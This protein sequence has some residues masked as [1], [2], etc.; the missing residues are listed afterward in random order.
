MEGSPLIEYKK[1]LRKR[2]KEATVNT[3]IRILNRFFKKYKNLKTQKD[4][5]N[6]IEDHIS[7]LKNDNTYNT[8][9]TAI[10]NYFDY[11]GWFNVSLPKRRHKPDSKKLPKDIISNNDLK[12]FFNAFDDTKDA[13]LKLKLICCIVLNTGL[14]SSVVTKLK[15]DDPIILKLNKSNEMIKQLYHEYL[16]R[17]PIL[18][19]QRS[20]FLFPNRNRY[21]KEYS[22]NPNSVYYLIKIFCEKHFSG[23]FEIKYQDL[24]N[25]YFANKKETDR[26]L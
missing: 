4:Y 24:Q 7:S 19:K 10:Q 26:D 25:Y 2:Y 9:I 18:D 13:E 12:R 15:V 22:M 16:E 1:F 17:R 6:A 11:K 5:L 3:Y 14:A 23:G 20:E 8:F 21:A